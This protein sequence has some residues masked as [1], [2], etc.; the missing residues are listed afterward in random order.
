M[1]NRF[2]IFAVKNFQKTPFHEIF[3]DPLS[4]KLEFTRSERKVIQVSWLASV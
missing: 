4:G 3:P 1:R 2:Y